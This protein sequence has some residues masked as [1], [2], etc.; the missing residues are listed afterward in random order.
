MEQ[1]K[2]RGVKFEFKQELT[3][4]H[5]KNKVVLL[6]NK[7]QFS[8][9]HLFNCAGLHSDEVAHQY[10][11]GLRYTM[12]P[13]RG[14]YYQLRRDAPFKFNTNL[15]PVPDL[16]FPFLGVHVTPSVDGAI[17]LGPTATPALGRE[18]YIGLTGINVAMAGKFLIHMTQQAI[19]N[20]KMRFYISQQALEFLPA[21]SLMQPGQLSQDLS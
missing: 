9:G 4:A 2:R 12:L 7:N 14:E 5:P 6:N 10:G 11:I 17:Y 16:N 15:Y 21:N 20:K 1:L 13:F 8:Y 19:V 18:N 3:G